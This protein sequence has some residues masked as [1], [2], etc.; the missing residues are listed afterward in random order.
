M[1]NIARWA[2]AALTLLGAGSTLAAEELQDCETCPVMVVI[3]S[4]SFER[5]DTLDGPAFSVTFEKQYAM[6]KFELT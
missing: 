3:P 4:G 6:A 1:K 2:V 5:S